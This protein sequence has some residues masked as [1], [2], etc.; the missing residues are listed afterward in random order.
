MKIV[1]KF[2][3]RSRSS[4]F[5]AALDNIFSTA[6]T[7]VK[8]YATL[9]IDDRI[10]YNDT[11][12]KRLQSYED[13]VTATWGLSKN[14]IHA[15]NRDLDK[16]EEDWQV[17]IC[18]SDDF[19]FLKNG[20][21]LEMI[22]DIVENFSDTDFFLH[23]PDGI[24]KKTSTF[25]ITGRKY[26]ERQ[27]HIYHFDFVS[28]YCDNLETDL[29]KHRGKYLF[30]DKML[31]EHRHPVYNKCDWDEQYRQTESTANYAKDKATYLRLRK[32]F[33]L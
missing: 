1:L 28:V 31:F 20:W 10:M 2:P 6:K 7:D 23:Y 30:I 9:D 8:V 26:F 4:K 27:N 22:S 24:Q 17:L 29:A 11:V 3:S 21:D 25:N 33:G 13:K 12:F 14:K 5:F 18:M 15:I 32:E 19:Y 16:I